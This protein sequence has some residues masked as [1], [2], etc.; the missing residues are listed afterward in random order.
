YGGC[1]FSSIVGQLAGNHFLTLF[2]GNEN[3]R[4]LG[5]MTLWQGAQNII[6]ALE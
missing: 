2:E 1:M 4:P 5:E 3:L 6:F